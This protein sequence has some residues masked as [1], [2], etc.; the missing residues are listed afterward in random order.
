ME[1]ILFDPEEALRSGTFISG[2]PGSGKTNLAKNLVAELLKKGIKIFVFDPSEAWTLSGPIKRVKEITRPIPVEIEI[3]K[4][5][6]VFDIKTLYVVE[7]QIIVQNFCQ[8]LFSE[9]ISSDEKK[10]VST[11]IVF[12]E[13]QTYLPEGR[14]KGKAYDEI[15]RILNIGRNFRLR[16]MI[17]TQF[18][19]NVDKKAVKPCRQKYIGYTDEPNDIDYL[20][21]WVRGRTNELEELEVGEFFYRCKKTLQKVT[22]PLFQDNIKPRKIKLLPLIVPV[23]VQV[24]Q[25]YGWIIK[26]E[27]NK[28]FFYGFAYGLI[29]SFLVLLRYLLSL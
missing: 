14:L 25:R 13:A 5:S 4:S 2:M 11:L 21:G 7:Q 27:S 16:I 8:K 6:C 19:A 15:T 9:T 23:E 22:I 10:R 29:I 17:L 28:K 1:N 26:K 24:K 20:K 3:P 12:E 18:A